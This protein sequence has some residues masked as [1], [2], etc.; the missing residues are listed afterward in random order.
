MNF[1]KITQNF[2]VGA[3]NLEKPDFFKLRV[4]FEKVGVISEKNQG[5]ITINSGSKLKNSGFSRFRELVGAGKVP[6]KSLI[7]CAALK[8]RT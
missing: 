7:Y 8:I 6:Q 1:T 2:E 5:Q 4:T 3:K